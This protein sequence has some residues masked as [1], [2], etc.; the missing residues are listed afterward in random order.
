MQ[1]GWQFLNVEAELERKPGRRGLPET[2]KGKSRE[3]K[4]D[5]SQAHMEH[6]EP[7]GALTE[8]VCDSR[9]PFSPSV[10]S[11]DPAQKEAG[12]PPTKEV[13]E[14]VSVCCVCCVSVCM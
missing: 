5:G 7:E 3:T 12:S 6:S 4:Q 9:K 1:E 8:K 14:G 13:C 11:V 2:R 10:I